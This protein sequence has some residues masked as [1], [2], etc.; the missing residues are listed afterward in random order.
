[1]MIQIKYFPVRHDIFKRGDVDSTV[2]DNPRGS[3]Y[4]VL[5]IFQRSNWSK[6]SWNLPAGPFTYL[7]DG[8]D[9]QGVPELTSDCDL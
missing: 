6:D 9:I 5:G 3:C 1:M 4:V 2:G 8:S 7:F